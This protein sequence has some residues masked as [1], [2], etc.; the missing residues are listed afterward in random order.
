MNR[1]TALILSL[2]CWCSLAVAQVEPGAAHIWEKAALGDVPGLTYVRLHGYNGAIT[3]TFEPLWAESAAYTV[4][5]AAFSSPYCASTST[6][7]DLGSTG[8]ESIQITGINTSYEKFTENLVMDGQTSVNLTT[9]NV[10]LI[11]SIKCTGA[12][13]G[14]VNAGAIACGTGANS[15]GDPAVVHQFM[16]VGQGKSESAMY[17]VP[18]NSKLICRN[19]NISLYAVTASALFRVVADYYPDPV[20]DKYFIRE[21]LINTTAPAASSGWTAF[22]GNMIVFP[23]RS[24]VLIQALASTGTGPIQFSMECLEVDEDW[25]DTSQGL[26]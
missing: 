26:F 22:P 1:I 13:S 25:E 9:T 15:S 19:P 2:L 4:L 7:D 5:T 21:E 11:N 10:L 23:E 6:S 17:G 18:D 14:F 16:A 8:C 3:T 12:G 24:I 20:A